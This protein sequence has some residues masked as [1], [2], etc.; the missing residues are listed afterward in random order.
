MEYLPW[1]LLAL[2]GYSVIAPIVSYVTEDVPPVVGLFLSTVI[3]LLIASAV[4][5]ATGGLDP[6]HLTAPAAGYVYVAG[7]FLTI[8]I[9]S[10]I[11]ALEAGPVSVVVPIYGMFI[12]G[13]SALGILFLGES[14]T[15]TRLVGIACAVVAI[16][17]G[18]GEAD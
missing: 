9:L 2:L 10:Y 12:V 16:V 4:L 17:L 15:G 1:T 14:L 8:G 5:V 7:V 6:A 3:F 18:A 13:S 11:A